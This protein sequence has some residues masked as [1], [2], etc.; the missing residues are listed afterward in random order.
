M[1][2]KYLST[3]LHSRTEVFSDLGKLTEFI[4]DFD[5]FDTSLFQN[6]KWKT[7]S[8]LA[9]K[10]LPELIK[11]TETN[12][13]NLHDSLVSYAEGAGYKKGQV[14]WIF[15][16]AITGSASTP[17]G[18]TEMATLFGK[19]ECLRRLERSLKKL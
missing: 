2:L 6:Q 19:E 5:N 3:L 9:A 18:A 10:M 4:A 14:L 8:A 11:L 12:F 15:R 1:D 7:D 16:I 17:G 13:E